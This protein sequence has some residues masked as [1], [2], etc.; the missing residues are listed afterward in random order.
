MRTAPTEI[1]YCEHAARVVRIEAPAVAE[2]VAALAHVEKATAAGPQESA[3]YYANRGQG[4]LV[5]EWI[6]T[7]ADKIRASLD[8][9]VARYTDPGAGLIS[10]VSDQPR[11][12]TDPAGG[13]TYDLTVDYVPADEAR[14]RP[15][16]VW[17]YRGLHAATGAPILHPHQMPDRT[18]HTGPCW[19][20]DAVPSLPAHDTAH[21]A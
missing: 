1:R 18:P 19:P 2:L 16:V 14:R 8:V 5:P 20:L 9:L 3:A 10:Q 21:R 15:G 4:H 12:W 6:R 13:R 11:T 17:R 7:N